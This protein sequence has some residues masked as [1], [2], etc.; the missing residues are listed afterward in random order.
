MREVL[1]CWVLLLI[2]F[3]ASYVYYG[4][5]IVYSVDGFT[6]SFKLES[7]CFEE[8]EREDTLGEILNQIPPPPTSARGDNGRGIW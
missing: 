2:G 3:F 1:A 6:R 7:F 4:F 8:C 5:E